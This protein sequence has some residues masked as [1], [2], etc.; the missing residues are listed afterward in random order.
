MI[1]GLRGWVATV[2]AAAMFCT[3]LSRLFPDNALGRQ[4]RRLVPCAFLCVVILP[5]ASARW[6]VPDITPSAASVEG[7][8][9]EQRM[10][11]QM[12]QRVEEMLLQMANQA[13]ESYGYHGEKV[14]VQMDIDEDGGIQMGQIILYV[15]AKSA[16]RSIAVKQIVEQRL[17]T[18]V[19]VA[20]MEEHSP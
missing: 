10:R 6:S 17:G 1:E 2:C 19:T 14:V 11:E 12:T 5:L 13:L 20:Q 16:V 4:G 9:L 18:A 15:D 8:A 7:E 3:V